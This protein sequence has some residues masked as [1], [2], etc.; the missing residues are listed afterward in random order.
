VAVGTARA[1]Y[2]YP[3]DYAREREQFG[4]KIG[5]NQAVAFLLADMATRIDAFGQ[6]AVQVYC[7][8]R[9]GLLA[10]TFW[11][12]RTRYLETADLLLPAGGLEATL[13]AVTFGRPARV[14]CHVHRPGS[15]RI[16]HP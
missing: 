14:H 1:A 9:A 12:P 6:G 10:A 3:R 2:E 11:H 16:R 15:W 4:R 8:R 5:E 7:R 13:A